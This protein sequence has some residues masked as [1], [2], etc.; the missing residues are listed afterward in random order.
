M[1]TETLD[2][3]KIKFI[4]AH[5][6]YGQNYRPPKNPKI[7]AVGLELENMIRKGNFDKNISHGWGGLRRLKFFGKKFR[8]PFLM[9][10]RF[11]IEWGS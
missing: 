4:F 10:N 3:R 5:W 2:M 7:G 11:G 9:T 1:F 6:V 8:F